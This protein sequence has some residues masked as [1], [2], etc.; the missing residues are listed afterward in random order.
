MGHAQDAA[1]HS[2]LAAFESGALTGGE[3][4]R[5]IDTHLSHVFLTETR[6]YKL[7]R[8]IKL[9]FVDFTTRSQRRAAC[10]AELEINRRQARDLYLKVADVTR[11]DDGAIALDGAGEAVDSVVVMRRFR[12]EDLFDTMAREGRLT[13]D[14]VEETARVIA[15][16]HGALEP[17]AMPLTV[18]ALIDELEE[19]ERAG[20][21]AH[22]LEPRGAR[23]FAGL[24]AAF[25]RQEE[26]LRARAAV[27]KVRHGHGDLHLRNICLFEGRP[28]LF[29][30]IEFDPEIATGD[31]LYDFAFLLMDLVHRD[32]KPLANRALNCYFDAAREDEAALALLPF[33]MALRAAVRM[34]VLTQGGDQDEAASYRA[35]ALSLLEP[36]TLTMVAIGGLSGT[37]KSRAARDL[38]PLLPGACG[39]RILRSDVVRKE[40]AGDPDYS[41]AAR[42]AVYRAL[43]VRAQAAGT[44]A[45]V[46]VDA[47]FQDEV[48]RREM[49]AAAG[50]G[51]FVAAWLG[52]PQAV[53]TERIGGRHADVSDA[54]AAVAAAQ[55]EPDRLEAPWQMIDAAGTPQETLAQLCRLVAR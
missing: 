12:D 16:F 38:A 18:A 40:E 10:E 51:P 29:D 25:A 19:T 43:F 28:T 3:R 48:R 4:P 14:L 17:C 31:V 52:A 41:P 33:L 20:A 22:G 9:P 11:T 49:V 5:R 54:D 8:A 15:A 34:A 21:A 26:L 47:T 36:R 7:K 55:H 23:V 32:L 24:R 13:A 42:T 30:A 44:G 50:A 39:A 46:I 1:Q 27:G 2:T 45:S 6:V 37:G 35:L 53:R